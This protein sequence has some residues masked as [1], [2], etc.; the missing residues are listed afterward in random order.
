MMER[1]EMYYTVHG[2]NISKNNTDVILFVQGNWYNSGAS[3]AEH[4]SKIGKAVGKNIPYSRIMIIRSYRSDLLNLRRNRW[5]LRNQARCKV[6]IWSE[7]QGGRK[8]FPCLPQQGQQALPGISISENFSSLKNLANIGTAPFH[9][10]SH[11]RSSRRMG[12]K[13]HPRRTSP[14]WLGADDFHLR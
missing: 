14:G 10:H 9:G 4:V 3:P 12:Q 5:F 6:P 7:E 2:T 1:S 8:P 13:A 11:S